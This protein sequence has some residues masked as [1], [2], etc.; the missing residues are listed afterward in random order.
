MATRTTT[1]ATPRIVYKYRIEPCR[2][3]FQFSE[4]WFGTKKRSVSTDTST[5]TVQGHGHIVFSMEWGGTFVAQ[6][7][8]K[9]SRVYYSKSCRNILQAFFVHFLDYAQ[10]NN[11]RKY[12]FFAKNLSFQQ[13][14]RGFFLEIL[15]WS[16]VYR[17]KPLGIRAEILSFHWYWP[18]FLKNLSFRRLWAFA[19][20][21]QK[22]PDM[23][24][25]VVC[26]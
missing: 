8:L 16:K 13:E 20:V 18:E 11:T 7:V 22:K 23:I 21:D 9:Y 10:L 2:F 4:I 3:F 6:G 5:A 1:N 14:N 12:E 15:S 19:K 26:G 24:F 17:S 25:L